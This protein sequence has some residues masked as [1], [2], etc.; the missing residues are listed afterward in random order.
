MDTSIK[1]LVVE[2]EPD[3]AEIV[4]D[5]LESEGVQID[6]AANGLLGL[7]ALKKE[8]YD[9]IITDQSMPIMDGK[10]MIKN[11]YAEK[12][13]SM[14][15]R[16]YL[17]TGAID[18][19]FSAADLQLECFKGCEIIPKPIGQSELRRRILDE[20]KRVSSTKWN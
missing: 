20:D 4:K 13:S 8:K 17:F 10:T 14:G 5:S 19:V 9:I 2:D 11:L 12:L 15:A 3:L 1:I 18:H 6:I 16:I 7:Q